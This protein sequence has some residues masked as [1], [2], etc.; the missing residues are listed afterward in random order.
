MLYICTCYLPIISLPLQI[1]FKGKRQHHANE[2]RKLTR[3]HHL[4]GIHRAD[5]SAS[6]CFHHSA[7]PRVNL[8]MHSGM[9]CLSLVWRRR[10]YPDQIPGVAPGSLQHLVRTVKVGQRH[11]V[12]SRDH[13]VRVAVRQAGGSSHG[14][15]SRPLDL[16]SVK[17]WTTRRQ[18]GCLGSDSSLEQA[19]ASRV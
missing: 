11:T 12:M 17:W 3:I 2:K 16:M 14:G 6:D 7:S 5:R 15:M 13:E 8:H 9:P 4:H 18:D 19:K 1:L 10:N